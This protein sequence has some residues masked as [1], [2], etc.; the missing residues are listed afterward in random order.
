MAGRR[1]LVTGGSGFLGSALV[2]GLLTA[3][4]A[5]RV[6]DDN[7]RGRPRRLT[8]VMRDVEFR[9]GDVRDAAAVDQAVQGVDGVCHLA[10]VNGTEFFYTMPD[11]VLEVAV[12][13]MVH[14][15]DACRRHGVEELY[16]ASS[17][18][19][20]Q[21]P[22][23]VPTDESAPL[24]VPDPRN[25]R[26]SYGGGKILG[27]L[28]AL[29]YGRSY[30]R[31]TVIFRPHNVYGP[32]MGWEHVLPQFIT[33]LWDLREMNVH[34]LPFPIQGTG[35]ET[36]AFVHVDDFIQGL[37]LLIE[38][39]E[40][41]GIYHIGH[42]REI[43]IADLARLTAQCFGREIDLIPGPAAPG[44]TLRRCPDISRL[45]ALGYQP[46]RSLEEALPEMVRWYAENIHLAPGR[47]G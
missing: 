7:S 37:L 38:R 21:T 32:D 24:S 9:H 27:E 34:P 25:P 29:H 23:L 36:R 47:G 18:E 15:M 31:R 19:V 35:Q 17:S 45:R 30:L 12:K 43:A 41:Q 44:G 6:L 11:V 4:C 26:Y 2:K 16:Y 20:Y 42:D 13:G 8:E 10:Y 40:H 46:R 33:R 14:V 5:V 28:M 3:G 1:F 39:G 22:P